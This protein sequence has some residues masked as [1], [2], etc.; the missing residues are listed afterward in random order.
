MYHALYVYT[1][2]TN[3]STSVS[4]GTKKKNDFMHIK[5]MSYAKGLS[6]HNAGISAR[7]FVWDNNS[8]HRSDPDLLQL[9]V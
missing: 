3:T 7:D 1:I 5:T 9:V 2:C 4:T 8:G 6:F